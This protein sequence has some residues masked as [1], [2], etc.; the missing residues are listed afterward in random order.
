MDHCLLRVRPAGFDG[1]VDREEWSKWEPCPNPVVC[2]V[3]DRHVPGGV[4]MLCREH[5][6]GPHHQD[7]D[8][9]E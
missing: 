6:I 4:L 5:S 9:W 8:Q 2:K 1:F 7:K 3:P